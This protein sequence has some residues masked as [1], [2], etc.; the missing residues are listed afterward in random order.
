M[1]PRALY[2]QLLRAAESM[3]TGERR[4]FVRERIRSGFRENASIP[5][6]QVDELMRLGE[7]Q[8]GF[9][10]AQ[11]AEVNSRLWDT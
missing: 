4:R 1:K 11:V 5:P 10:E 3:P 7:A 8:L 9:I 2:R 6:E